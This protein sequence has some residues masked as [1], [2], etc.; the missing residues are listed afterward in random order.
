MFKTLVK[1]ALFAVAF[2][3]V[4]TPTSKAFAS[5]DDVFVDEG[6]GDFDS[7][8][9][10]AAKPATMAHEE[11]KHEAAPV[12]PVV[13]TN[14]PS[15]DELAA[16]VQAT[17]DTP[18]SHDDKD[19]AD[20]TDRKKK[21]KKK[22]HAAVADVGTD[23]AVP[24]APAHVDNDSHDEQPAVNHSEHHAD[25]HA[26]THNEHHKAAH[27]GGGMFV[28]TKSACPMTREPASDSAQMIVVKPSHKIWVENVDPN[29]VKGFNKAGEAGYISRDCVN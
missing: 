21:K 13:Q 12:V 25:H 5:G 22:K 19:Y 1:S 11:V 28:V 14:E 18:S 7:T 29:W 16:P 27:A 9:I 8:P 2:A 17:N 24:T 6:D 10:P 3:I 26:V 4:I 15:P 23:D 20:Q